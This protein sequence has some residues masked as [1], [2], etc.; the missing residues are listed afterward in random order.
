MQGSGKD[1]F[2]AGEHFAA[3]PAE[4]SRANHQQVAGDG[5]QRDTSPSCLA[6]GEIVGRF[7]YSTLLRSRP[8][9]LATWCVTAESAEITDRIAQLL[10]GR[11]HYDPISGHAELITASWAI[12]ILLPGLHAL[13]VGWQGIDKHNCNGAVRDDGCPCACP[14]SLGHRRSE[15]KQ[16]RGCQ[17]RAEIR[18]QLVVDP[19]L[20]LFTLLC[21]DWSFVE[22]AINLQEALRGT[23][24]SPVTAQL[25][26][27]RTLHQLRSG[28]TLTYTRPMITLIERKQ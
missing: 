26:L 19:A 28:R 4:R 2:S 8:R 12:D 25:E 6:A 11:P 18:F 7:R 17:P 24:H 10:G 21:D 27:L 20:G 13:R 1:A 16:G 15:A 3:E 23:N 9:T 5:I 14:P 22:T